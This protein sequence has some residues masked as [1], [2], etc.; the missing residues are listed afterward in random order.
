MIAD[1]GLSLSPDLPPIA[2]AVLGAAL[3][4]VV[5]S[6]LA[7]QLTR[8]P[9]GHSANRGRSHCDGCGAALRWFELVPLLSWLALKGYCRRCGARIAWQHYIV[10]LLCA[11]AGA[12]FFALGVPMLAAMAWLLIVLALFDAGHL[13]LPDALVA[14][15]ALTAAL[16]P[17]A[18]WV[19]RLVS[20]ALGFA[21][22]WLVA[23]GFR[24]LTGRHGLG[25]GDAKLFGAIG[26]WAGASL[27]LV[28][29]GACLIGLADA[30]RRAR[31]THLRGVQL[32]LGAYLAVAAIA[33]A[34]AQA[35]GFYP[36]GLV[37]G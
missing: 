27:P 2:A 24:A 32:P 19:E 22:L 23:R 36:P 20:A 34:L 7:T 30:A 12:A 21:A 31:T 28:M 14:W 33:L 4:L 15:L 3:G 5:G 6:Y 10:E 1:H 18:G 37:P 8:W 17:G 26:L 35:G 9:L 13:W 16:A 25:G 11:L 29:I